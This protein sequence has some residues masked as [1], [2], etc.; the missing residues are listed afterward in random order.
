MSLKEQTLRDQLAILIEGLG[1]EF[2]GCELNQSRQGGSLRI[3]IDKENGAHIGNWITALDKI[4]K[5]F[6][7]DTLFICGHA[8]DPE[9]VVINKADIKAYQ[10]YLESLLTFVK[11]EMK[12]G[13]T[14]EEILKA[15]AIPG[16][17]EWQ[18]DG[19]GRSLTAAY[20]ELTVG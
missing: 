15:T 11:A 5:Q 4:Q 10:N 1:Y 16:A 14:K 12:A 8:L 2:V 13:K 3:Y 6:D 18:G 7:N 9:K 17:P 19:I 20:Q